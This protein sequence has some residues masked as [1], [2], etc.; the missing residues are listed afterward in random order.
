[1]CLLWWVIDYV[2][3]S[4]TSH[5]F[6][7]ASY[8]LREWIENSSCAWYGE[9]LIS[10]II[11]KLVMCLLWWVFDYVCWS[12][13]SHVLDMASYWLREWIE[14]SSCAWYGELLISWIIR[15]LVMCLLWW[16]FHYVCW[17]KTSL[18]F[19]V[20]SYWLREWI[21][22]SSCAWYGEL[23]IAWDDRKL[24]NAILLKIPWW[25]IR[26]AHLSNRTHRY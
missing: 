3:W 10:W 25:D 15:K 1:M 21:E 6:D 4:K 22:N 11:R 9:L 5:V 19:D 8:W 12:K 7:V 17:S 20:A 24:S 23:L 18:V 16:V 26:F 2:C 14:N 13:T